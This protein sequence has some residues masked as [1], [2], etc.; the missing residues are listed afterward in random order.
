MNQWRDDSMAQFR[1][2]AYGQVTA[3]AGDGSA[4]PVTT[5]LTS[6]GPSGGTATY[7][8]E[9]LY[10]SQRWDN[11][12]QLYYYGARFYDPR[13]ASFASEDP[14]REYMNPYAYVAWNPVKFTDPTGMFG[15][16]GALWGSAIGFT[17]LGYNGE[18]TGKWGWL[19][20]VASVGGLGAVNAA[21][22]SGGASVSALLGALL[23]G[24]LNGQRTQVGQSVTLGLE[25]TSASLSTAFS[26]G[27]GG[28]TTIVPPLLGTDMPRSDFY[29]TLTP[30]AAVD[31]GVEI[32]PGYTDV[33]I[34]AAVPGIPVGSTFGIQQTSNG[35]TLNYSGF[36]VGT[37][38]TSGLVSRASAAAG[39]AFTVTFANLNGNTVQIGVSILG[40]FFVELGFG[41]PGIA[42]SVINAEVRK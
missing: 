29:G 33:S 14:A 42:I 32:K 37:P 26:P 40:G 28:T 39:P 6:A 4:V 27:I 35:V 8:P 12:A 2:D 31:P 38:G 23:G 1:I 5:A 10:T 25:T 34:N 41:T 7:V 16:G 21:V 20:G 11:A 22:W 15:A 13:I 3:Y 24:W 30:A 18:D 17:S 36:F 9:R 19:A